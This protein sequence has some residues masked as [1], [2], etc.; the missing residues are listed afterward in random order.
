ME[1]RFAETRNCRCLR[2]YMY[3]SSQLHPVKTTKA[4]VINS[5]NCGEQLSTSANTRK[6]FSHPTCYATSICPSN[7]GQDLNQ[8]DS[9]SQ[10][11]LAMAALRLDDGRAEEMV[12]KEYDM[13]DTSAASIEPQQPVALDNG[14]VFVDKRLSA[15]WPCSW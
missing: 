1:L 8:M 6:V 12:E 13:L 15:Y 4:V 2:V 14:Y 5:P 10:L 7:S 3:Q 9:I 11:V